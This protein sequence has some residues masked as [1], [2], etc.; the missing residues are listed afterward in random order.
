MTRTDNSL[1]SAFLKDSE[2]LLHSSSR[3]ISIACAFR[4]KPTLKQAKWNN[5]LFWQYYVH[6]I[7]TS[8]LMRYVD[9]PP[10][11]N[12]LSKLTTGS[13]ISL[14]QDLFDIQKDVSQDSQ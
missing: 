2:T 13:T 10:L 11:L 4:S 3:A 7:H 6:K 12:Q 8:Y 1:I 14:M 9:V 5:L